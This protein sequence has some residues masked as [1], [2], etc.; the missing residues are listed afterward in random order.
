MRKDEL[1]MA[2][3]KTRGAGGLGVAQSV[4][5]SPPWPYAVNAAGQHAALP[6][7]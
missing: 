1:A 6:A 3:L 4:L 2:E 7:A 5:K